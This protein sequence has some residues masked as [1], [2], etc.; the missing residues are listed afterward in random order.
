[1]SD[2]IEIKHCS[3]CPLFE[4]DEV[5]EYTNY[6]RCSVDSSLEITG[7]HIPKECPRRGTTLILTFPL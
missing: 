6:T 3:M 2:V 5:C 7:L 1:M 4:I